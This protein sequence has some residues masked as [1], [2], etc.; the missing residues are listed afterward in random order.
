MA[1]FKVEHTMLCE[2]NVWRVIEAKNFDQAMEIVKSIETVTDS[3]Q[4][5]YEIVSDIHVRQCTI[6][7]QKPEGKL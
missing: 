2:V 7:R 4:C 6:T 3:S 1:L 5:D